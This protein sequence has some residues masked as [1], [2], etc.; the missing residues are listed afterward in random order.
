[1]ELTN[2]AWRE[3]RPPQFQANFTRTLLQDLGQNVALAKDLEILPLD[4]DVGPAV[5]AVQHVIT[6]LH[7]HGGPFAAIENSAGADRHNLA[8]L[9]LLLSRV[10]KDDAAGR[11]F[12]GT[13]GFNDAAIIQ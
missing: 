2:S 12:F 7:S 5:L 4:L 1:M 11:P 10:G 13:R 8:A 9:R 6:D 3:P